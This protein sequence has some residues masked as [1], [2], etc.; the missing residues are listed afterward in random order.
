MLLLATTCLIMFRNGSSSASSGQDYDWTDPRGYSAQ[1]WED[2][3]DHDTEF[4]V[5]HTSRANGLN[6][7]GQSDAASDAAYD[8]A[9]DASL[10]ARQWAFKNDWS[11][12]V[13]EFPDDQDFPTISTAPEP[14]KVSRN[15]TLRNFGLQQ[16]Q[17]PFGSVCST[18]I[19]IDKF[20]R[21]QGIILS[22]SEA[23]WDVVCSAGSSDSERL[24]A[25]LSSPFWASS[26]GPGKV[27][28]PHP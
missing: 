12:L 13:D 17:L 20:K 23:S 27:P 6:K 24:S 21:G 5:N 10:E 16:K 25:P 8:R 28:Q 22:P 1:D 14:K 26:L 7:Q 11:F 4:I 15:R 2:W 3:Q 18:S 19:D 9:W